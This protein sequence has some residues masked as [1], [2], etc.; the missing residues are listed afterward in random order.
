MYKIL[1]NNGNNIISK[2][3]RNNKISIINFN[4]H[5]YTT[6]T[7]ILFNNCIK[8]TTSSSSP[9]SSFNNIN[10]N[11][12]NSINNIYRQHELKRFYSSDK[13]VNQ[14]NNEKQNKDSDKEKQDKEDK[15]NKEKKEEEENENDKEKEKGQK[16]GKK[17]DETPKFRYGRFITILLASMAASTFLFGPTTKE[18]MEFTVDYQTFRQTLLPKRT[19]DKIILTKTTAFVFE[20]DPE[21]PGQPKIH[22]INIL[23]PEDFQR[24]LEQDQKELGIDIKDQVFA[25]YA[26]TNQL[27]NE[28]IAIIPTLLIFGSLVLISRSING[29][30]SK[31]GGILNMMPKNKSTKV[32]SKTT[33]KDVAG[34]DEAKEEIMEFV[35]F[36]KNP[37]KYTKLGAR[38]PK[39]AILVGPPGTGKTLLAKATAGEAGVAFFTISGSDFIEMFVGVGPSRVRELFKEARASAPCII[40]IDE[41]DAVGRSRSRGGFHNDERENTLNQLLVEMDGF[42]S[43]SNVI[44]FAGTNRPDVLD[45]ALLRPGRFDRQI[46]IGAPDIKGRKDIFMVHLKNV[47]IEGE[48]EELAKQLATLTPGFSGADISNVCNEGALI[49]ARREAEIATF[50][51]FE[52]AIERVLVGLER[53]SRILSAEERN[54]VAHHEAGHAIVGWFLEHTDPLLKVSITPRGPGILGFAQYQPKDQYLYSREQLMDRICVTLGGRVA[55]SIVFGRISTGAADDLEKVTKIASSQ[56]VHYGMNERVGT[57]SFKKESEDVTVEKPY[58][59]ATSRMI[60]E[61]IRKIVKAAYDRTH[62]LLMSKKEELLKLSAILLEK[63]VILRDD[64]RLILGPRPYGEQST[65]AELT[66]ESETKSTTESEQQQQQQSSTTTPDQNVDSKK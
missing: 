2:L 34:L 23:S 65:W 59:Q 25:T 49:A 13:N 40:F 45:S 20:K 16:D 32:T 56:V 50:K 37:Q 55:E 24:K 66:G 19:I 36:L 3:K 28:F 54:I 5:K 43:T 61:E 6:T 62:D 48:M 30:F 27:L 52:K 15:E 26:P 29:M 44:V 60:D 53:K 10:N 9:L 57:V 46:Y 21:T 41:I 64:L 14:E 63:E 39:G 35:Q 31:G 11:N 47:K 12:N 18:E 38:I 22:R 7:N 1:R 42:S 8:S 58:S 4:Q 17:E 33:F 51:D